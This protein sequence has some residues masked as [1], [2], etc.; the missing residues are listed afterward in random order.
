MFKIIST[1]AT[2]N[3]FISEF[4]V[5][6]KWTNV[7]SSL[8][9]TKVTLGKTWTVPDRRASCTYGSHSLTCHLKQFLEFNFDKTGHTIV[10]SGTRQL[11]VMPQYF[12]QNWMQTSLLNRYVRNTLLVHPQFSRRGLHVGCCRNISHLHYAPMVSSGHFSHYH[13]YKHNAG[14][15][16]NTTHS[17]IETNLMSLALLFHYLMLIMFRM[18][19][20]PCSGACDLFVKL[21]QGLYCSGTMCVDVTLWFGWGGVVSR[22]RL[23]PDECAKHH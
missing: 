13:L 8:L 4:F 1:F 19:I 5:C 9:E 11:A 12:I 18:L 2:C 14:E 23:K 20:H 6:S 16:Y 10:P 15:N 21:F 17:W 22:C 3:F 7:K